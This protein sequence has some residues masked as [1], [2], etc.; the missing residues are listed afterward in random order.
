MRAAGNGRIINISSIGGRIHGPMGAWY[1]ASKFALEGFSDC[2]RME[3]QPFGIEVVVVQPG[4]VKTEWS[5]EAR[6]KLMAL[7]GASD[8]QEQAKASSALMEQANLESGAD[9][10]QVG[11]LIRKALEVRRPRTRYLVGGGARLLLTLRWL[12]PDRA[13]DRLMRFVAGRMSRRG[14]R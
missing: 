14:Q 1:H 8:Y 12:L 7:S 10:R 9:P 4:A 6:S 11:E 5:G 13:F 3:L 2:L